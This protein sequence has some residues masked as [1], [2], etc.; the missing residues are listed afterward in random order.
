MLHISWQVP[1]PGIVCGNSPAS[2][3][4]QTTMVLASSVL[5]LLQ[6]FGTQTVI[7]RGFAERLTM[8]GADKRSAA[9]WFQGTWTQAA[10][11]FTVSKQLHIDCKKSILPIS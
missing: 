2:V 7:G 11:R 8:S 5:C 9:H 10:C 3:E 6:L 1:Q 4:A